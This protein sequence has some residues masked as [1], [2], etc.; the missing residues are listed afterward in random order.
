[1]WAPFASRVAVRLRS[2]GG[3]TERLYDLERGGRGERRQRGGQ[4]ERG[5]GGDFSADV[6]EAAAGDDY[7]FVVEHDG[8]PPRDVPDPRS[9]WQPEG[10][11]GPSRIVDLQDWQWNDAGW[12]GVAMPELVIYELHVGTFTREGTFDAVIRELRGLRALGV[13][14]IEIMPVAEFPGRRNWGY[15]GVHLYAPQDSYGGPDGL[16]R[17]VDAAHRTGLAVIL[18]VVYNHLGPEGNYLDHFGPYFTDAYRTPWGRALNYDGAESDEVRGWVLDNVRQW[19]RDYHLDGLRLDAVH[20]ILDHGAVHLLQEIARVVHDEGAAAGRT[21]VCIAES[22]Q[23]DPRLLRP[24][25]RG[26]YALDGQWAD[27]FHHAVHALLTGERGGY[28]ADFGGVTPV[29]QSLR[30]PFVYAGQYSP[31]RRRRHGAP[32]TGLP[33]ERFV[34]SIQNHDQVGNRATGDR[35]AGLVDPP[36]YRLAA[37]LLLLAPYVPLIF[38]GEEYGETNPFQ[39]FVHHSDPA[40]L[41]AVRKGRREEFAAFGWE[42][43]VP[44]PAAPATF[45]RSLVGREKIAHDAQHEAVH[46]LYAALLRLRSAEP[47]LRPGAAPPMVVERDGVIVMRR[48]DLVAAFN[49]SAAPR[50]EE[51]GEGAVLFSSDAAGFGGEGGLEATRREGRV[52]LPAWSAVLVKLNVNSED[53]ST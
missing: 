48:G 16:R 34:V 31:Y 47:A 39:Y 13:T 20:G 45:E 53:V 29:A 38:M 24:A 37:S 6:A 44:D 2:A 10:V 30:E 43:E 15:D 4:A 27:D 5:Q 25:D 41:E 11:H 22:D 49:C 42:A 35:L 8:E 3:G 32:S 33:R 50:E 12:R 51:V 26:G 1:M 36:R 14:A 18:D 21:T 40:L 17:L 19:I 9:R 46:R 7:W 23:N 52:T 28:Y